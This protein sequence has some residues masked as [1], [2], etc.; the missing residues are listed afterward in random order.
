MLR[1]SFSFLSLT[2]VQL[3]G[4]CHDNC[5]QFEFPLKCSGSHVF[6]KIKHIRKTLP[7]LEVPCNSYI[8]RLYSSQ[9]G[10]PYPE[11]A[12][13]LRYLSKHRPGLESSWSPLSC[14]NI[15]TFKFNTKIIHLIWHLHKNTCVRPYFTDHSEYNIG[16]H[17][18]LSFNCVFST[19]GILE[20]VSYSIH[21]F[22]ICA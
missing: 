11:D 21:L 3:T 6:D 9:S 18:D 7:L 13:F 16:P 5:T 10:F 2:W 4:L 14:A 20:I 17:L 22:Q 12:T 1:F 19:S 15:K 8:P